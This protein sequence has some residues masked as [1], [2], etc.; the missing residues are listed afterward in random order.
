MEDDPE[1]ALFTVHVLTR[2]GQLEVIHTA[3][4]AE[5]LRLAAAE[6]WDLL[7]TDLDL[8]GMTGIELLAAL[9]EVAPALPVAVTSAH[10]LDGRWRGCS[11]TRMSTWRSRCGWTRS[12]PPRP[13]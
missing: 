10:A 9:R 1:A 5:A 7:L 3:D 12:S 8:P 13:R 11:A 4:P 6:H 2:R